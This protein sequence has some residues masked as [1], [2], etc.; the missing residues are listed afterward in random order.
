MKKNN[1]DSRK[2]LSGQEDLTKKKVSVKEWEQA[3]EEA[4]E[5]RTKKPGSQSNGSDRHNNGRGGGK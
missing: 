5:A 4:N 2:G 3:A 1:N